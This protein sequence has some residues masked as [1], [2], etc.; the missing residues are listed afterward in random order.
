MQHGKIYLRIT[1]R[2]P[3]T[4]QP[5]SITQDESEILEPDTESLQKPASTP[6]PTIT[7]HNDI[8]LSP[9]YRVPVL[10]ITPNAPLSPQSSLPSLLIP[11]PYR[12]QIQHVGVMGAL[13]M[14][15][16]PVSGCPACFLHPCRTEVA[17]QAVY[18][19]A[20]E[21]S[22]EPLEYLCLW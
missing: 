12:S 15:E 4:P 5:T 22:V 16:H 21:G 17:M 20:E 8:L 18:P 10:Y 13:S 6:K 9:T 3:S 7:L 2:L 14:T 1:K 11:S 19:A